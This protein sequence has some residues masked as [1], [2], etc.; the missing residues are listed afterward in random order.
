MTMS[1]YASRVDYRGIHYPMSQRITHI[2][3]RWS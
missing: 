1:D 2:S 3:S